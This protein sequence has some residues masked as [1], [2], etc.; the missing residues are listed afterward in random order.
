MLTLFV[1]TAFAQVRAGSANITPYIG[2]YKFENNEDTDTSM[3]LG[4]RLG[5]N[6]TKYV[7]LEGFA[8]WVPTDI[9]NP[10][11]SE[12][13]KTNMNFIGYG[14]DGIINLVP[15][16]IAGTGI[17]PFLA[18][19]VGGV[20]YSEGYEFSNEENDNKFAVDYGAGVKIFLSENVA[21][22]LDVR[23][24]MPVTPE[25]PHNNLLATVGLTFAFGGKK[26]AVIGD[27]D[28]DGVLDNVD[29]C[30]GTPRGCAVDKDG[31]PLDSDGDGVIDC[32]DKCP[33]TPA[34]V[35][36]DKNGCPPPVVQK[37]APKVEEAPEIIE[38]GRTTLKVLF[39]TDKAV[40][41][42]N[43][44]KDVDNLINVM[45]QYPELSVV[46]EGHTDDV[47]S[48]AYNKKLSQKRA[49]AVKKYMVDKGVDANRMQAIGYGE[50]KPIADNATKE[51]KAQ[52]RRVEAAV[53]YMIKK[54]N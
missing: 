49:D 43:S 53:D 29:K 14:V 4:L 11:F 10:A 18:V 23:H 48:D 39:D 24:V 28:G 52:N 1:S 36:V 46:I 19:G 13:N 20:H 8:H 15:D 2:M 38:K 47:G 50:E 12:H 40:I 34:G 26:P 32:R 9:S 7:G 16:G 37:A 42:K 25:D 45:K 5:Y 33:G 27:E 35:K 30:P 54:S 3:A 41:K 22:R 44:F 6:F 21:A 51:G 17:V 31:C